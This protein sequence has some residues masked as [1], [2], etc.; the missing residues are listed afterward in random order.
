MKASLFVILALLAFGIIDENIGRT[1]NGREIPLHFYQI[2]RETTALQPA[3][4]L[5]SNT[6][7]R[8]LYPAP[9]AQA[10]RSFKPEPRSPMLPPLPPPPP[11]P[12]FFTCSSGDERRPRRGGYPK[13]EP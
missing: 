8:N 1:C 9:K 4:R 7:P 13:M 12:P 3:R 6:L 2:R 11:P 10:T 5:R